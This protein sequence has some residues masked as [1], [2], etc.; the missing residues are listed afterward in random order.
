M[1][2]KESCAALIRLKFVLGSTEEVSNGLNGD[3]FFSHSKEPFYYGTHGNKIKRIR[4]GFHQDELEYPSIT[5]VKIFATFTERIFF[6]EAS[7]VLFRLERKEF[8]LDYR[9]YDMANWTPV[10]KDVKEI[11][12]CD[13]LGDFVVCIRE[14]GVLTKFH[15]PGKIEI[16]YEEIYSL[17]PFYHFIISSIFL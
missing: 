4:K 1:T 10:S 6:T 16:Q 17:P 8:S 15:F 3:F 14:N 9:S 7:K 11:V 12:F 5:P 2:C 13:G